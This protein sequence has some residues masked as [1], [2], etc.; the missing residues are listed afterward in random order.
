MRRIV[1]L[2]KEKH[3]VSLEKFNLEFLSDTAMR[4]AENKN[5]DSVS[6]YIQ[7]LAEDDWELQK[8]VDSLYISWSEFFRESITFAVL[9]KSILPEI[10]SRKMQGQEIRIWS[11]GCA[12]G[13]EPYSIAMLLG[14]LLKHNEKELR[15]RI[16]ATD[17]SRSAIL[18]AQAGIYT[19][20]EMQTV[21]LCFIDEYFSQ[22][23]DSFLISDTI[24]SQ[25]NFSYHDIFDK[26]TSCPPESIYGEFD[27]ILCRNLLIYYDK[28]S[29]QYIVDK[30]KLSLANEGYLVAGEAEKTSVQS[31]S[32]FK[33]YSISTPIFIKE[34]TQK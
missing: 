24:K 29:Q 25:V 32:S 14:N 10:I 26:G 12:K 30:L 15:V 3:H 18:S 1:D 8:F 31:L 20:A 19:R 27:L 11:L 33:Y 13:Q 16:F 6:E 17:I 4:I 7:L 23:G 2:V 22:E 9:N 34:E 28:P 21:P 5:L